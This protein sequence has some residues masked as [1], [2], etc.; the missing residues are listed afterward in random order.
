[1]DNGYAFRFA[2]DALALVA[3]FVA[4]ERR[5]CP[6]IDFEIAIAAQSESIWLRMTG[7]AGTR[8]VL[9]AEL[10]IAQCTSAVCCG[11]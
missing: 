9:D 6:F 8:Q 7:P 3:Q 2:P 10:G 5:C 4:N 11:E 1:M